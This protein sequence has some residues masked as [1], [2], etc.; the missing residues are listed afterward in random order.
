[1][2]SV[3]IKFYFNN[4][5]LIKANVLCIVLFFIF[6]GVFSQKAEAIRIGLSE[7]VEKTYIGSTQNAQFLDATT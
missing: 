7:G 5:K 3:R 2:L 6:A 1:M 4:I